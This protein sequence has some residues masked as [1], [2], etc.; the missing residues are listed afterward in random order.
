MRVVSEIGAETASVAG[1]VGLGGVA[2]EVDADCSARWPL[3]CDRG[4]TLCARAAEEI[5]RMAERQNGMIGVRP[6]DN[7]VSDVIV[8]N[9]NPPIKSRWI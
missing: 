8:E 6:N 1:I 7:L 2:N 4:G 9:A 5:S 3:R